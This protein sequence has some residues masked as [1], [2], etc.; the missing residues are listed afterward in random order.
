MDD[1]KTIAVNIEANTTYKFK[2]ECNNATEKHNLTM[3][4]EGMTSQ[5]APDPVDSTY[6]TGNC[7]YSSKVEKEFDLT[8]ADEFSVKCVARYDKGDVKVSTVMTPSKLLCIG[9]LLFKGINGKHNVS[10]CD[11]FKTLSQV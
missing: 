10:V 8:T 4:I 9:V 7:L 1:V 6:K 2:C 5:T 11:M 3:E